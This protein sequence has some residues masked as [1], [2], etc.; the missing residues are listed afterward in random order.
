MNSL[1]HRFYHQKEAFWYVYAKTNKNT[2][3]D[4]QNSGQTV[5]NS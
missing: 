5:P 4:V 1:Q 3:S 2:T